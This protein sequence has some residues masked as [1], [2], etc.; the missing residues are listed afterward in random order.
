[1]HLARL[2]YWYLMMCAVAVVCIGIFAWFFLLPTDRFYPNTSIT[3]SP[4][5]T[6]RHEA[7]LLKESGLIRSTL[8]F[9]VL[10]RFMPGTHGVQSGVY[11]FSQPAGELRL[12][13]DLAHGISEVPEVKITFPEGTTVRQMGAKLAQ[14][15]PGVNEQKF[16]SLALLD[17]GYLFPDT[18]F[19]A[20]DATSSQVIAS[21]KFNFDDH[22]SVFQEKLD[23]FGQSKREV[24][25]M[26]SILEAEAK[27]EDD[28]RIVSGIL[29]KRIAIGMPLQV[30]ATFGYIYGKTGY[31]PTPTDFESNSAYNTYRYKGLPPTPINNPGAKA[32]EA[33]LTPTKSPYLYYLTGDDGKMHYAQTFAEHIA[34][35]KLYLK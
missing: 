26:A 10:F 12:A 4:G 6:T 30:D 19:L 13:W 1:M 5:T 34:N 23:A 32:I 17:E 25:T 2:K 11:T 15:L 33:A 3:V 27:N 22:L 21:L 16:D 31:A 18:Y 20:A 8:L 24:V 35:Q 29:W 7:S 9:R 14:V 28:M